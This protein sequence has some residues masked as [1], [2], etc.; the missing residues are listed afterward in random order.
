MFFKNFRKYVSSTKIWKISIIYRAIVFCFD[1]C[2]WNFAKFFSVRAKN[3]IYWNFYVF[4][5]LYSFENDTF[6][7]ITHC[8]YSNSCCC[9]CTFVEKN[10]EIIFAFVF[11]HS[12]KKRICSWSEW[13]LNKSEK[14][15]MFEKII[16]QIRSNKF[17]IFVNH[18]SMKKNK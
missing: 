18:L 6:F 12:S 4:V 2:L 13:L 9:V 7:E 14:N 17:S 10:D 11:A 3:Q 15:E 16:F 1:F 8:S 5:C